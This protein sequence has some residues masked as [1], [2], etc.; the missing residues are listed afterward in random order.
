[1][2]VQSLAS[3]SPL[4]AWW[5]SILLDWDKLQLFASL[6]IVFLLGLFPLFTQQPYL[7]GVVILTVVYAYVGITWN[8]VVGFAGQM[9]LAHLNFLAFGAFTT[10]ILKER[11]G[12]TPWLGLFAGAVVAGMLGWVIAKITLRY[13]LKMDYFALF[14]IALMTAFG[15]LISRWPLAGGATGIGVAYKGVSFMDMTFVD[16][17]PYL[18]IALVI[19]LLG[20]LIQYRL[21]RSKMGKYFLAIRE[22]EDAA[23]TL[24]VNL[25]YYKT[26]AVVISA[27]MAG[28]GGGFYVMYV[29]FIDAPQIFN[30]AI[31]LEIVMVAPLIGGLGTLIGPIIGSLINKP[32]AE[33]L[34]VLFMEQIGG[35]SLVVYGLFLMLVILFLPHGITKKIYDGPYTRLRRRLLAEQ[36]EQSPELDGE[37]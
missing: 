29:T 35:S 3:P 31:N 17:A 2:S 13:G 22:N 12:V 8:I 20:I 1:M 6:V 19:L 18:Y 25:A 30:L 33:L 9:L 4:K 23:A 28:F 26:M 14:T 32:L 16:K 5:R 21:Y 36:G 11:F 34:R 15:P 37:E 27:V 10:I 24:G 7:L